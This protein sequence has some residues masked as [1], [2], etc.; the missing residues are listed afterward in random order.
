MR[1][2][3]LVV[4]FAAGTLCGLYDLRT[5][6]TQG[7]AMFIAGLAFLFAAFWPAWA[8]SGAVAIALGVPATYLVARL[9]GAEIPYPPAPHVGAT[10]LALL[11]AVGASLLGVFMRRVF[12][13]EP[14]NP[15]RP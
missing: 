14:R 3:Y 1:L 12:G 2:F 8:L 9:V 15:L 6:H 4:A 11:P 7:T 13:G 5:G 10:L